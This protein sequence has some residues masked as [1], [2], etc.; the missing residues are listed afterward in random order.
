MILKFNT[1][2]GISRSKFASPTTA[3]EDRLPT[4]YDSLFYGETQNSPLELD[5][6]VGIDPDSYE[7]SKFLTRDEIRAISVWLVRGS[8]GGYKWLEIEQDD[9]ITYKYKCKLSSYET[10]EV[11][12]LIVGLS[13][14]FVC[15][16]PFGYMARE[17][18]SIITT[19]TSSTIVLSENDNMGYYYPD[20]EITLSGGVT[21]I[22]IVNVTDNNRTTTLSGFTNTAG[23]TITINNRNQIITSSTGSNFYPYF[24]YNFFR[25]L[26]G[27]N[28]ITINGASTV[29]IIMD[30]VP[31]D[32][33]G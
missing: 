8:S 4:R 14:K 22:S 12:G 10:I 18:V 5:I 17:P 25:L 6:T 3:I 30:E 23:I 7:Q 19:T 21:S 9:L 16:S 15:D 2:G 33:G 20:L 11:G 13:L 26:R 29:K 31:V 32:I 28:S 1:S 24:N 27:E